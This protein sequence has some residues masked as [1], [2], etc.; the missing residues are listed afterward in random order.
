MEE[1]RKRAANTNWRFSNSLMKA[2]SNSPDSQ[3]RLWMLKKPRNPQ[4]L[5]TAL[6]KAQANNNYELLNKKKKQVIENMMSALKKQWEIINNQRLQN[7]WSASNEILIS[8]RPFQTLSVKMGTNWKTGFLGFQPISK[9][10]NKYYKQ[11][12]IDHDEDNNS[13]F[14]TIFWNQNYK[15]TSFFI[16]TLDHF[17]CFYHILNLNHQPVFETKQIF[18]FFRASLA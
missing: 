11:H 1:L 5:F 4:L 6:I 12:L 2:W 10:V 8:L 16:K 13:W 9:V 17:L 15:K 7:L 3:K 18:P 14:K